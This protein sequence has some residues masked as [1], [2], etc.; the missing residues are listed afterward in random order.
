MRSLGITRQPGWIGG[1]CAGI[2]ARLGIDAIIVRGIVVVFALFG[3]PVLLLY[4]AA[5]LLLPDTE[6]RIH[7]ER[8][9]HGEFTP[10]VIGVGVLFLFALLPVGP[11]WWVGHHFGLAGFWSGAWH[12]L[13]MLIVL[14]AIVWFVVW[15]VHRTR[16]GGPG[17]PGSGWPGAAPPRA[18]GHPPFAPPF[19]GAAPSRGPASAPPSWEG[20]ASA[21]PAAPASSPSPGSGAAPSG[22]AGAGAGG[23]AAFATRGFASAAPASPPTAPDAPDPADPAALA[24]WKLRQAEWKREYDAWRA[25]QAES[26]EAERALARLRAAEQRHL[27][28]EQNAARQRAWQAR[29]RRTRSNPLYSVIA[30]GLSLVAGATVTLLLGAGSWTPQA[31]LAGVAVTLGVCGLAVV[32]NGFLGRRSGG[33]GGVAILAVIALVLGSPFAWVAGPVVTGRSVSWSPSYSPATVERTVV[34][35]SARLDL[36]HYFDGGSS[37]TAGSGSQ[38][39][40]VIL[41]VVGGPAE[42]IVPADASSRVT[43][44]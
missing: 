4:A 13:W 22:V 8:L 34:G 30:I 26:A 36:T 2:A 7:L 23:S 42:V 3:G 29:V 28:Q 19:T 6:D 10:P 21:G 25:G 14:G 38:A 35:G 43:A 18:P 39:G 12:I 11:A 9:V 32:V 24:A 41:R 20:S 15:A 1:V 40:T 44:R 33:A 27:R 16:A 37:E 17:G 31:A 5:W